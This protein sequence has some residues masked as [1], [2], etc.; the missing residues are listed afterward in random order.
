MTM[1]DPVKARVQYAKVAAARVL[2]MRRAIQACGVSQS[3]L[4]VVSGMQQSHIN[5]V[6]RG[7]VKY[8]TYWTLRRLEQAVNYFSDRIPCDN[9]S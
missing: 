2:L 9:D 5:R 7:H 8:P 1:T 4:A 3:M 6:L